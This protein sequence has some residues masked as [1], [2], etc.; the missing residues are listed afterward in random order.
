MDPRMKQLLRLANLV[1]EREETRLGQ[2]TAKRT[3]QEQNIQRLRNA[4]PDPDPTEDYTR[5]GGWERARL[6]H[7]TQIVQCNQKLTQIRAA[8][9][10]QAPRTARAR[11]RYEVL[12]R[13][14]GKKS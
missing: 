4:L 5:L 10:D 11:A 14:T 12:K 6:W 2:I 13:M 8:Q 3:A 7:D 9:N 1:R